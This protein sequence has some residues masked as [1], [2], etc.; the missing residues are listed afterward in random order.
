MEKPSKRHTF[1]KVE[2]CCTRDVFVRFKKN[3][4]ALRDNNHCSIII[5]YESCFI[6]TRY[7]TPMLQLFTNWEDVIKV[8]NNAITK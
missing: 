7:T 1:P 4:N 6:N 3:Y 5:S 8:L 2:A